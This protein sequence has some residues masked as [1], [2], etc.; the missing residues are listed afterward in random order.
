MH[1]L[2]KEHTVYSGL[3]SRRVG[4]IGTT[5]RTGC[6][7][8]ESLELLFFSMVE[9]RLTFSVTNVLDVLFLTVVTKQEQNHWLVRQSMGSLLAS[10]LAALPVGPLRSLEF[11]PQVIGIL[12]LALAIPPPHHQPLPSHFKTVFL[13]SWALSSTKNWADNSCERLFYRLF[14]SRGIKQDDLTER[15]TTL[16]SFKWDCS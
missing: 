9:H 8:T 12:L 13:K 11:V 4:S 15:E 16:N 2:K 5:L 7:C 1:V 10:S 3:V 14:Q 6:N